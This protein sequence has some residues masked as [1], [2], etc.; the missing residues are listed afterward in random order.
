[1]KKNNYQTYIWACEFNHYSGEGKLSSLYLKYL[2]ENNKI[3]NYIIECPLGIYSYADLKNVNK[4]KKD[5]FNFY[6]KYITP[7]IGLFKIFKEHYLYEKKTVYLNYIPLWNFILFLLLPRKTILGPITGSEFFN[8]INIRSIFRNNIIKFLNLISKFIINIKY[9]NLIFST[10]LIKINK[11][12]HKYLFQ[13]K[14][15]IKKKKRKRI[16]KKIDLIFYYRNH[17][18]KYS[19][20]EIDYLKKLIKSGKKVKIVGDILPGLR[21]HCVG[22]LSQKKLIKLLDK[23]KYTISS[24]ENPFSFFIQDAILSNIKVIFHLQ[25]KKYLLKCYKNYF[26]L[27]FFKKNY[28]LKDNSLK[29]TEIKKN[30]KFF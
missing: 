20:Y 10:N 3:K 2:L 9:S 30:I 14:Y 11:K 28:L 29:S 6:F 21:K 18:N 13:L 22:Y 25:Q 19:I 15:S 12:N 4:V 7:L 27:N 26:L 5:N 24:L 23:S 16:K 1:M 17:P 8:S